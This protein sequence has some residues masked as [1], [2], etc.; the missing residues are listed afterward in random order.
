[1]FATVNVNMKMWSFE[2]NSRCEALLGAN[3]RYL[4][5]EVAAKVYSFFV[6]SCAEFDITLL[7]IWK[8]FRKK[9]MFLKT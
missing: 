3:T 7:I 5:L 4:N 6:G 8:T 9:I 1:M 2:P